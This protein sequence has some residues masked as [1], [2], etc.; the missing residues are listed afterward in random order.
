MLVLGGVK[1]RV[2]WQE[3]GIWLDLVPLPD[4]VDQRLAQE[5][6]TEHRDDEGRLVRIE[7]DAT[8]YAQ[9]V[10]RHCIKAWGG[11][12]D[13]NG[14]EVPCSPEAIDEFMRIAPAQDFVFQRIKGL[15]LYRA[16]ELDKAGK[17]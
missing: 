7:R 17:D 10:G 12:V 1:Q 3:A 5:T 8:R 2:H 14:N 9:L 4:D 6:M 16:Q 11:V 13:A 15:A